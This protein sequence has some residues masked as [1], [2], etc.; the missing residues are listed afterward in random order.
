M[1]TKKK[2]QFNRLVVSNLNLTD[3]QE[4]SQQQAQW[5][6]WL[7]DTGLYPITGDKKFAGKA[8]KNEKRF[9]FFFSKIQVNDQSMYM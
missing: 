5:K 6:L 4:D 1:Y 8:F 3:E 2:L 7:E 9:F